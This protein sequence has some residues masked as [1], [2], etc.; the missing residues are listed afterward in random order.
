MKCKNKLQERN[1]AKQHEDAVNYTISATKFGILVSKIAFITKDKIS[2]GA[3][4]FINLND[5]RQYLNDNKYV[6]CLL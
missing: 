4:Y 3:L 5:M 6:G 1:F 2:S